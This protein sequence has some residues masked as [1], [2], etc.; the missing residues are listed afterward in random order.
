[1]IE[2]PIEYNNE[3]SRIVEGFKARDNK[4]STDWNSEEFTEIKANIKANYKSVQEYK[5]PYCAVT[6]PVTHGMA[7]DIEHIISKDNKVQFMFEPR[8]LCVACKDC[9]GAKS[10]KNVLENPNRRRFPTNSRDYKIVH[11][12]FDIYGEHINAVVPGSFYRPLTNKG[13]FTI[14]TCRLLRFYGVVQREQPDQEIDDLAKALIGSEGIVR[15]VIQNEL[16]RRITESRNE[17]P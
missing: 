9:N 8:N 1:M 16:V 10:S 17:A 6:Y 4:S 3:E 11:P 15:N 7:W 5:C 14:I 12:H 2:I 13:E